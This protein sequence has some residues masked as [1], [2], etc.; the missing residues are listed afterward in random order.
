MYTKNICWVNKKQ[1]DGTDA[2][3]SIEFEELAEIKERNMTARA[4]EK[5]Y[6]IED[7]CMEN[8]SRECINLEVSHTQYNWWHSRYRAETKGLNAEK[9]EGV[10]VI[11]LNQCEED[12]YRREKVAAVI[13]PQ[14]SLEDNSALRVA[15]ESLHD[16]LEQRGETRLCDLMDYYREKG[17]TWGSAVYISNKYHVSLRTVSEDHAKLR[18]I[19]EK[20]LKDYI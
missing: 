18:K 12:E 10:T 8:G 2:L 5:R 19:A 4:G 14:S 6:F 13:T 3:M 9:D 16:E 20:F 15:L 7:Y 17:T 11:S 1:P